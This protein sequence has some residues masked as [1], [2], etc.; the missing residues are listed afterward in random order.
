MTDPSRAT[1][2]RE[3]VERA[4]AVLDAWMTDHG[5]AVAQVES[6][7]AWG[8]SMAYLR[9]LITQAITDAQARGYDQGVARGR[10]L[11]ANA[12]RDALEGEGL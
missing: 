5:H 2:T 3:D 12:V 8:S 1:I 11:I 9:G 10:R 7:K 4:Q 6:A